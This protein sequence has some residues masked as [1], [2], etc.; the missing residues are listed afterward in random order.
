[1]SIHKIGPDLVR[2]LPQ[3]EGG[4]AGRKV[5]AEGPLPRGRPERADRVGFSEEGLALAAQGHIVAEELSPQRLN[6]IRERIAG[7]FYDDP[8][9]AEEVA[10]RILGSGERDLHS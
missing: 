2:S 9:V 10:R 6:A 4:L 7:G 1:M 3:R 5:S 8:A